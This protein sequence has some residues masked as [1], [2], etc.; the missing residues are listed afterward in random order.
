MQKPFPPKLNWKTLANWVDKCL[1]IQTE[2]IE[3]KLPNFSLNLDFGNFE[4]ETPSKRV[5]IIHHFL[6]RLSAFVDSHYSPC[7]PLGITPGRFYYR[8]ANV[9]AEFGYG[10]R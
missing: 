3:S 2:T 5:K 1:N 6:L 4:N 7:G 10:R 9:W 8:N